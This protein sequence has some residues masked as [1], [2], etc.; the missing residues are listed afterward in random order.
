[1]RANSSR[2]SG[3]APA[4]STARPAATPNAVAPTSS[5]MVQLS[6]A[7]RNDGGNEGESSSSVI[8]RPCYPSKLDELCAL[9]A[10]SLRG[11]QRRNRLGLG[12]PERADQQLAQHLGD[13]FHVVRVPQIAGIEAHAAEHDQHCLGQCNDVDGGSALA[14]LDRVV[15]SPMQKFAADSHGIVFG[16]AQLRMP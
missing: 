15:D 10:T 12:P 16:G 8:S 1:M 4:V 5:V 7:V 14:P 11:D 13:S 2:I 9:C 6:P 3:L